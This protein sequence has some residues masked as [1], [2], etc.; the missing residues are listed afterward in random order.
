VWP[1]RRL[2]APHSRQL[3][4]VASVAAQAGAVATTS[5]K[6]RKVRALAA[7]TGASSGIGEAFARELAARGYDL[8][9]VARRKRRLDKLAAELHATHGCRADV[10]AADLTR[11]TALERVE[12]A[13]ERSR[14]L[15]LL[16][17][18]AGMAD[19]GS[20]TASDRE[21]E[22]LEIRLNVIAVVRLT[23]AALAGMIRRGRG[24]I[25]NVSSTAGFAPC[26]KFATYGATKAF[27]NSFTEAL[28]GE[29]HDSEVKVQALCPGLTHT[30]IFE[31]A[32]T[33]TS[34][35]PE[36]L[37]MEAEQVVTESLDALEAGTV[38]CVPGLGN[39]ALAALARVLPHVVGSRLSDVLA[40]QVK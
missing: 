21:R 34:S 19:F 26:P 36:F 10:L 32:G 4:F 17:N 33:D 12:D 16:V 24:A 39:R 14:R 5:R 25:I 6:S 7:V 27:V 8:L 35:L 9:L 13:L 2:A 31:R 38:I 28:H 22:E 3:D 30:E 15:A 20:F 18:D 11:P 37:W 29:L 40:S 23:H 1:T